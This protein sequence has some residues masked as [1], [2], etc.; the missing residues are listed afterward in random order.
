M[1]QLLYIRWCSRGL[2]L[3]NW[4]SCTHHFAF[5][6]HGKLCES[7]HDQQVE[8]ERRLTYPQVKLA[9]ERHLPIA[10]IYKMNPSPSA[11]FLEYWIWLL[12]KSSLWIDFVVVMAPT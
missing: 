6:F 12:L 1:V 8:N 2:L 3:T 10:A 7:G 9:Y 11:L 4:S 5:S